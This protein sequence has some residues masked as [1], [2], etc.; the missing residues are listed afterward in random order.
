VALVG[1][2]QAEVAIYIV[3]QAIPL[4]RVFYLGR[5]KGSS[6][7]A[8]SAQEAAPASFVG[9]KMTRRVT[10]GQ[11]IHETDESVELVQLA[12]GRIVQ[13]NSEEG[14]AF[15]ASRPDAGAPAPETQL[16]QTTGFS[17]DDEV[18]RI[19]AEMGLSRRAWS[20]SPTPPPAARRMQYLG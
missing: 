14:K 9:N 20:R 19:W 15:K 6:R 12:S 11:T 13:G 4:L 8:G 3:A 1:L 10:G 2:F 18:H 7:S 17:V 16:Q 5:T